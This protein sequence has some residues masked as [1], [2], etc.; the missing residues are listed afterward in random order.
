MSR[1]HDMIKDYCVN[2]AK[3]CNYTDFFFADNKS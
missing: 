1:K 2:I 3:K